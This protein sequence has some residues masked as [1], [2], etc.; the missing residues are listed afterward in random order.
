MADILDNDFDASDRRKRPAFITVLCI[1]SFIG[2]GLFLLFALYGISS[3]NEQKKALAQVINNPYMPDFGTNE[4]F[5]M[6]VNY[7]NWLLI[8]YCVYIANVAVCLTGAILMW[9]LRRRGYFI[10]LAG[11]ILL[12]LLLIPGVILANGAMPLGYQ[13]LIVPGIVAAA[14]IGFTVLYAIHLKHLHR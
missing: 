7:L 3:V 1:L 2:C 5:K 8:S 11:Q 10:Y 12:V 6:L 14:A 4:P 13:T 9:K